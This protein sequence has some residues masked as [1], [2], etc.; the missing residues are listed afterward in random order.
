MS[1]YTL[2]LAA[3]LLVIFLHN[4]I[5]H[6]KNNTILKIHPFYA[7]AG[8]F[9]L[10]FYTMGTLVYIFCNFDTD[11]ITSAIKRNRIY[12]TVMTIFNF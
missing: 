1:T 4:R 8:Y 11:C 6:E 9:F 5:L 7:L 12:K 2:S 10:W 3:A